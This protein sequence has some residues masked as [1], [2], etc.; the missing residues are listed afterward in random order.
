MNHGLYIV[1]ILIFFR[2]VSIVCVCVENSATSRLVHRH[3][4]PPL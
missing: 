4:F 1:F 2:F 3:H